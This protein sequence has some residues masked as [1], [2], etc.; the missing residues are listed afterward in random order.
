MPGPIHQSMLLGAKATPRDPAIVDGPVTWSYSDLALSVDCARQELIAHGCKA[1]TVVAVLANNSKEYIAYYYG[2]L[3]AG[4]VVVALNA[5]ERPATWLRQLNHCGARITVVDSSIKGVE[6][7]RRTVNCLSV[8]ELG[9][10]S[11]SS[12]LADVDLANTNSESDPRS[13]ASIIYT[14]GTTGEPKGIMLSHRNLFENMV[15][16]RLC[17]PIQSSDRCLVVLPFYY[18]FGNSVLH[19]HLAAGACLVLQRNIAFPQLVLQ[20]IADQK[21]TSVY[22]VPLTFS[23]L[24]ES[25]DLKNHNLTSL[26]YIGQAGGPMSASQRQRLRN[27]LPG[28][29]IYVMYGQTEATARLTCLDSADSMEKPESVGKPIAGVQIRIYSEKGDECKAGQSGEIQ[30]KGPNVMMGYWNDKTATSLAIADGWL[31]TGDL[32]YL[33]ADGYLYISGRAN[34]MI[35]TG[36]NRVFPAEIEDV[37]LNFPEVSDVAV[38]GVPDSVLGEKIG[39]CIVRCNCASLSEI[40]VRAR[41]LRNLAPF[42]VPKEILF[43]DCVPRTANGKTRRNKVVAMLV[44]AG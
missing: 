39:A 28:V 14:S 32:G 42:K 37:I 29:R 40:E 12:N 3:A 9:S 22:G 19:T 16:I 5:Q 2:I 17:L 34:D 10:N 36:A 43:V 23:I 25:V 30:V 44:G 27:H 7:I 41:C 31:K 20:A 1:G 4:G 26:K 11:K 15:A 6:K 33:D 38:A 35:K 13:L 24:F 18:S 21:I 8:D